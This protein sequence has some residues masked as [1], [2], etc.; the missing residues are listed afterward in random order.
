[1]RRVWFGLIATALLS[2]ACKD[3]SVGDR[4]LTPGMP[5]MAGGPGQPSDD[6]VKTQSAQCLAPG[7]PFVRRLTGWEYANTVADTLNVR[8]DAATLAL[9]PPDFRANGFSNDLGAQQV[10]FDSGDRYAKTA[11]AVVLALGQAPNWLAAFT[12]CNDTTAA[13]RDGIVRA[14]G[15]RLYRRP[16][17]LDESISLAAL[18]DAVVAAGLP[19][20]A[21]A[22][23]EVVGAMLQSPQFLYRLEGQAL[24]GGDGASANT[25]ALDGYEMASRLS[26]LTW[27]SAPDPV[28]LDAAAKGDLSDPDKL[29]V[30][31]TR[32]LAQPR[33][34]ENI[35]RYFREWL[36]LDDLDQTAV[37]RNTVPP[38]A[39]MKKETLDVVADQ[40]WDAKR[41]LV[42]T[43]LTTR[44][45]IVDS[46]LA[47]Y[48]GLGM[49]DADGRLSL[50]DTPNRVGLLTHASVLTVH[51]GA[52]VP[53]V[54]RGLF[55]FRNILC[56]DVGPPP[57]GATSIAFA[58]SGA[59][60]R[61]ESEARLQHQPCG[62]CHGQFDPLGYAFEP[63][64]PWGG[65]QTTDVSGHVLR[66]DGVLTQTM[67]AP[68]P[69]ANLLEYMDRLARDP[70]VSACVTA[71]VLQFAW[72][73][74]MTEGDQ[75]MLAGIQARVNASPG[76]AFADLIAAIAADSNLRY[77][78]VQ[79]A[80]SPQGDVT[81]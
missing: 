58:P 4:P 66:Q 51:G 56:Q 36:T 27:G 71:K 3:G 5:G 47:G 38:T 59:S 21:E 6:P 11:D 53:I 39:A 63:F 79:R 42:S 44:S 23:A 81:P 52:Q 37:P 75:C 7:A 40:L 78:V 8:L 48:Y 54:D 74:P 65:F 32:M 16:V 14:L 43:M 9:L 29:R 61:D 69:Y 68:V 12:L 49:P 76:Q 60:Q 28:L 18:F 26:Y 24:A 62:S 72:G 34:R 17:T 73:R 55:V 25:R 33:A 13:C 10:L 15:L 31:V 80:T 77:A 64:D 50:A 2:G 20:A 41:P 22:A 45:T 19:T 67:G 30:Q 1:M 35:Q 57:P 46:A 70:R